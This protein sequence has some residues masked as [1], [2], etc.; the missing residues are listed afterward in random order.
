MNSGRSSS[1]PL[2]AFDLDDTLYP[3]YAYAEAAL[4]IGAE[5]LERKLNTTGIAS[6]A[7]RLLHE[8]PRGTRPLQRAAYAI[9]GSEADRWMTGAVREL[10]GRVPPLEPFPDVQ[11]V[12]RVLGSRCTLA[13]VTDGRSDTQRKKLQALSLEMH[14]SHIIVSQ[15]L[16]PGSDKITGA[17]YRKLLSMSVDPHPRFMVGDQFTKDVAAAENLGFV[18]FLVRRPSVR[19]VHPPQAGVRSYANLIDVLREIGRSLPDQ[20]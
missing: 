1:R 14:F 11:E 13:V 6:L 2:V 15:D 8:E 4:R 12:L 16:R 17:P 3:E 5:F 7:I 18:G 19:Y 9:A 20:E 10:A